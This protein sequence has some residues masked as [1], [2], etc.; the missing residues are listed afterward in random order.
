[1]RDSG[2]DGG[3]RAVASRLRA[4]VDMLSETIG[5]RHLGRLGSIESTVAYI[6]DQMRATG[7]DVRRETYEVAGNPV[8]NLVAE[9][10]GDSGR[11]VV[12]GAH[13]DTVETTPGADDNGSAVAV[14]LET[15]R[16]LAAVR[17]RHTIRYVSFACEE[18]PYFWTD[19]MGSQVHARGCRTRGEDLIGM[20]CLEMV[21]YFSPDEPQEYP[22]AIPGI[23]RRFL[24]RRGDFLASVGDLRSFPLVRRFRRGYRRAT[25]SKLL[26]ISL[27]RRI[28]EIGLS[29]HRSFWEHGYR[30]LMLTDTSFFRNPNYHLPTDT[31]DTL[32]YDELAK[33]AAGVAGGIR[34]LARG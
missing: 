22:D 9:T 24:P 25:E 12:L 34:A 13:Y 17:P 3:S 15:M 11:I 1:M 8:S 30:A 2:A 4:H 21:G 20:V 31:A 10:P 28:N 16:T 23:A 6:E 29:D 26:S 14:L 27:P 33:V 19:D 5:P 18:P 32:D 7:F